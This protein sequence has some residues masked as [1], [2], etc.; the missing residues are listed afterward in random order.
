M[1]LEK[2]PGAVTPAG[3]APLALL[4]RRRGRY[5]T[6][7]FFGVAPWFPYAFRGPHSRSANAFDALRW[8]ARG[9]Y[10][11]AADGLRGLRVG[12]LACQM[13]TPDTSEMAA[14]PRKVGS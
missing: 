6:Q 12:R 9:D 13:T 4:L 11:A 7:P 3:P 10:G 5:P 8:A 14:K 2:R 1:S